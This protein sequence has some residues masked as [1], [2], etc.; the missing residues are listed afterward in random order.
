[1]HRVSDYRTPAIRHYLIVSGDIHTRTGR[2]SSATTLSEQSKPPETSETTEEHKETPQL[3][4]AKESVV[5]VLGRARSIFES[6]RSYIVVADR[7]ADD[8]D[9]TW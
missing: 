5:R 2:K 9:V 6:P 3:T 4:I 1:M 7:A 8:E